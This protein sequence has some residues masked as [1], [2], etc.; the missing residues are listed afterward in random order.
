LPAGTAAG[1]YSLSLWLP[2]EAS[3]LRALPAYAVRFANTDI[4][5]A[6]NGSNLLSSNVTVLPAASPDIPPAAPRGLRAR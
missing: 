1:T 3:S 5:N 2:D 6:A 4:W